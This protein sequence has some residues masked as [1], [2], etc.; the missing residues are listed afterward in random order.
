MKHLIDIGLNDQYAL[1]ELHLICNYFGVGL[2]V[3]AKDNCFSCFVS[4]TT[5]LKKKNFCP[6]IFDHSALNLIE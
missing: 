5:K 2:N 3:E 6:Y 1:S 4:D